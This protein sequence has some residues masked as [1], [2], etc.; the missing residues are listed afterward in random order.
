MRH[1][2][3]EHLDHA[4]KAWIANDLPPSEKESL[5]PALLDALHNRFAANVEP[6][7]P[8]SVPTPIPELT[9]PEPPK[10]AAKP[11]P[12]PSK[13]AATKAVLKPK[14]AKLKLKAKSKKTKH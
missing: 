1:T 13:V 5:S 7:A 2:T 14:H 3:I 12:K 11:T 9:P 10:P 6:Q 8:Q 4:V